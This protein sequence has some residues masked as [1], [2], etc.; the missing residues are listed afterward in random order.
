MFAGTDGGTNVART[1][2]DIVTDLVRAPGIVLE[3]P[4]AT[5]VTGLT[6]F[7]N[8]DGGTLN[9]LVCTPRIE[10]KRTNATTATGYTLFANADGNILFAKTCAGIV[11]DVMSE[12]DIELQRPNATTATGHTLPANTDNVTGTN[13]NLNALHRTFEPQCNPT[14]KTLFASPDVRTITDIISRSG[15]ELTITKRL[16]LVGPFSKTQ[17]SAS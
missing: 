5:T 6:R 13:P 2:V 16:L 1:G 4:N 3:R 12:P 17:I 15:I 7:P 11:H 9:D 8:T 10:L 14:G